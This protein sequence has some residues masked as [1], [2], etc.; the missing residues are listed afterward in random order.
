MSERLWEGEEIIVIAFM[1]EREI[2]VMV[3]VEERRDSCHGVCGEERWISQMSLN[4]FAI[5]P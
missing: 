5:L 2:V 1:G 3:S 4:S